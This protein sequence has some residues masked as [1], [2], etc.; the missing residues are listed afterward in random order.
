MDLWVNQAGMSL[1]VVI[2][3][4]LI[5]ATLGVLVTSLVS[6]DSDVALNQLQSEQAFYLAE[7]GKEYAIKRVNDM[8]SLSSNC[9]IEDVIPMAAGQ[10]FHVCQTPDNPLPGQTLITSWAEVASPIVTTIQRRTET[11]ITSGNTETLM[12]GGFEDTPNF[13]TNWPQTLTQTDGLSVLDTVIFAVGAQSLRVQNNVG[14][15]QRFSGYREQT[16]TTPILAGTTV[17]LNL[18]YRKQFIGLTSGG[19]R[20]DMGVSLRY[21]TGAVVQIWSNTFE[22]DNTTINWT[23]D[24]A[25]FVV[26]SNVVAVRLTY[27]LRNRGGPSGAG[28]QKRVWFDDVSLTYGGGSPAVLSW[29]EIYN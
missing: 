24:T 5:F 22:Q 12:D 28:S 11:V 6:S 23:P 13:P 19:S 25:S 17:T 1:I 27:D 2:V 4:M 15:G 21:S 3:A 7:A 8:T 10:T 9:L 26:A 14:S 20:T 16:L 29:N 18:Q